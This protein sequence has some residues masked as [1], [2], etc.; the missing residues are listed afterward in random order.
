MK[1]PKSAL[2]LVFGALP[3]SSLFQKVPACSKDFVLA[4]VTSGA[5]W[6]ISHDCVEGVDINDII[7]IAP[8]LPKVGLPA[9]VS[10]PEEVHIHYGDFKNNVNSDGQQN[11]FKVT[12]LAHL[13]PGAPQPWRRDSSLVRRLSL[14]GYGK[15]QKTGALNALW[16][17]FPNIR[18]LYI[19]NMGALNRNR[20]YE[21]TLRGAPILELSLIDCRAHG[22]QPLPLD[23]SV[24]PSTL[25]KLRVD[26]FG[27]WCPILPREHAAILVNCPDLE[28]VC[29]T[30][31][32]AQTWSYP[33]VP[34][35]RPAV[36]P[37]VPQPP[38]RPRPIQAP[39]G[40]VANAPPWEWF[41]PALCR[42]LSSAKKLQHLAIP[43]I[44]PE[45][46]SIL[47]RRF[48][49]ARG[50]N[51]RLLMAP[52]MCPHQFEAEAGHLAS[53]VQDKSF[54]EQRWKD[55]QRR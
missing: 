55:T 47:N 9:Q 43:G 20:F 4:V 17:S 14:H 42:L 48:S 3:L 15:Q 32:K 8:H 1:L 37:G 40:L 36:A 26:R 39:A 16:R 53:R 52:R 10:A 51:R 34:E 5:L 19:S 7:Q 30:W 31:S 35:V 12:A 2:R 44:S 38:Q 41:E 28:E 50:I 22:D 11:V 18:A 54:E 21:M 33:G 49:E 6:G 27:Q 29:I 25:R 45:V 13:I 46:K 24:F 23:G